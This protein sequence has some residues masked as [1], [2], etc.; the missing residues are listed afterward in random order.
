M[1]ECKLNTTVS[2]ELVAKYFRTLVNKVFKI[3][4][5]I[6]NKEES[7]TVYMRSLGIELA[8]FKSLIPSVGEDPSYLS[9]LSIFMWLYE[10]IDLPD[11]EYKVIRSEVFHLISICKK[12]QDQCS[13]AG[14][15]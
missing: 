15:E 14:E 6:E 7:I 8:G 10:H 2:E 9:L 1:V 4:P 12:M 13:S 3:L 5:I 11:T